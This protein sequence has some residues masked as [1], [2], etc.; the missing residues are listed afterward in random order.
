V[1]TP[2]CF[3]AGWLPDGIDPRGSELRGRI[4]GVEAEL[5]LR[6]AMVPRPVHVSGWDMA[7]RGPKPTSVMVAPGAVYFFE[8]ADGGPFGISDARTLWL[9]AFGGRTAE[10]FGRVVPGVWN[11]TRSKA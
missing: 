6:A 4:R 9:A 1:V 5:V 8:R 11:P 2:A 7:S 3:T 10:G